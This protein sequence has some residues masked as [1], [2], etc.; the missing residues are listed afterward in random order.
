LWVGTA[1]SLSRLPSASLD[2]FTERN[3][4][5]L[6][7]DDERALLYREAHRTLKPNGL[8]LTLGGNS[9]VTPASKRPN[10][11]LTFRKDLEAF[12]FEEVE[13][14]F[15]NTR[16][17]PILRNFSSEK[18]TNNRFWR[19]MLPRWWMRRRSTAYASLSKKRLGR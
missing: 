18:W 11:P 12:G 2:F 1:T 4:A 9:F 15:Y 19:S 10:N 3:V 16:L 17:P 8:F 6:L 14:E 7:D 13:Q 5:L